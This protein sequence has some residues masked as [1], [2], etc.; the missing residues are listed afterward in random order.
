MQTKKQ[1]TRRAI[2]TDEKLLQTRVAL[3]TGMVPYTAG[4]TG[5]RWRSLSDDRDVQ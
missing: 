2:P 3:R 4:V 1:S 5:F